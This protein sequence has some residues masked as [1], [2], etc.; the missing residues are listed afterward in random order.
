MS[1]ATK[2]SVLLVFWCKAAG[3]K[4]VVAA[5]A[6]DGMETYPTFFIIGAQKAGT[7]AL[8]DLLITHPAICNYGRKEKHF[9]S[10]DEESWREDQAELSRDFLREFSGCRG[11]FFT[12]DSTPSYSMLDYTAERIKQYY[13][14]SAAQKKF[15]LLLR[16]P[17]SRQYSEYQRLA[18][19]CLMEL[20]P[21]LDLPSSEYKNPFVRERF[22][23]AVKKCHD[24]SSLT[25]DTDVILE[26]RE[27]VGV[28][29]IMSF[30]SWIDSS[31]GQKQLARGRYVE[32]LNTW[33]AQFDRRQIFIIDFQ[34][35]ISNTTDAVSKLSRWLGVDPTQLYFNG[36][37]AIQLPQVFA[38]VHSYSD[39]AVKMKLD[40]TTAL[41]L[42]SYYQRKNQGLAQLINLG[43]PALEPEFLPFTSIATKCVNVSSS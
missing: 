2:L 40:C 27:K 17:V 13:P 31:F 6:R 5:V 32:H 42:E 22:D 1:W 9:F 34:T 11:K 33:L 12:L 18:R 4:H 23:K 29:N 10:A 21:L 25:K 8:N 7:T 38:G 14:Q 43:K 15:V 39:E 16:E 36:T 24:V 3:G 37:T 35:L 20:N 19:G 30:G 41:R 28:E 26:R